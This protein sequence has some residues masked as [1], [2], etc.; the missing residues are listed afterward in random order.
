MKRSFIVSNES[1]NY[2]RPVDTL[3]IDL[4]LGIWIMHLIKSDLLSKYD[5]FCLSGHSHLFLHCILGFFICYKELFSFSL[6]RQP[7]SR[8]LQAQSSC[9]S[10]LLI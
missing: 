10:C 7:G 6:A 5:F 8:S 1:N 3:K 4:H 9:N 2:M